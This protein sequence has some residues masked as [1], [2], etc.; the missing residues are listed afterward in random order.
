MTTHSFVIVVYCKY[1]WS[2]HC[3]T[4]GFLVLVVRVVVVLRRGL[5]SIHV[6]RRVFV[7]RLPI[8]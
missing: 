5:R 1:Y 2:Q 7:R 8:A 6:E 3:F 4:K